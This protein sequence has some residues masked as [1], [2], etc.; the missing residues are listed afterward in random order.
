MAVRDR[1]IVSGWSA[2]RRLATKRARGH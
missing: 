1:P 2:T